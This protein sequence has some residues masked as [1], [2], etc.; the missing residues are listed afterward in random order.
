MSQYHAWLQTNPTPPTPDPVCGW[1]TT[2][3]PSATAANCADVPFDATNTPGLPVVCV[4]WCDARDFCTWAGKRLCGDLG[5]NAADFAAGYA[6]ATMD[7]WTR[8]CSQAG[9]LV[10]PYGPTYVATTCIGSDFEGDPNPA[11]KGAP[12]NVASATDCVGGYAGLHDMSGNVWEWENSCQP[13]QPAQM[14][15]NDQCHDRGG[16]FWETDR[17]Q[18]TCTAAGPAGHTRSYQNKNI[19]FRC[20]ADVP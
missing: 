17:T 3:T 6:D 14:P 7:E 1:N 10:Y 19:G 8:A 12:E 13:P 18:L 20:C 9:T 15:Q 5:G 16:S 4:D 2:Y 11:S